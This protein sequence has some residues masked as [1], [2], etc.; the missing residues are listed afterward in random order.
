MGVTFFYKPHGFLCP[1]PLSEKRSGG[2][3]APGMIM[4]L[5]RICRVP[6]PG[7]GGL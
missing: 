3:P 6:R 5:S 7:L 1:A 4:D 2:G